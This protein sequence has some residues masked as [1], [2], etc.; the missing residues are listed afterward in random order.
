MKME[1]TI[2]ITITVPLENGRIQQHSVIL[3][4]DGVE[5]GV[6]VEDGLR[7]FLELMKSV[8]GGDAVESL[9]DKYH[10]DE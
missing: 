7:E 2:T 6:S 5:N 9:I 1:N 8:W 4:D 3:P 10:L